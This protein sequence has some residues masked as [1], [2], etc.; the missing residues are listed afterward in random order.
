MDSSLTALCM[1]LLIGTVVSGDLKITDNIPSPYRL[2]AGSQFSLTCEYDGGN[3]QTEI[4]FEKDGHLVGPQF[5]KAIKTVGNKVVLTI[6]LNRPNGAEIGDGGEFGCKYGVMNS[7]KH[8]VDIFEVKPTEAVVP[9]KTEKDKTGKTVEL[10]CEPTFESIASAHDNKYTMEWFKDGK[11]LSE[12]ESLKGRYSEDNS[13]LTITKAKR[14]DMGKYQCVFVFADNNDR[15][16]QTVLLKGTPMIDSSF[17]PSKNLVQGDDWRITCKVTGF[18]YPEVYWSKEGEPLPDD[19]R[20]HLED[21]GPYVGAKLLIYSL[22]FED[23]GNYE[24]HS[25]STSAFN[26]TSATVKLRVKDRLATLW[27]F[28]G[29]VTEVIIMFFI[30]Q[31]DLPP[32]GPSLEL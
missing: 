20:I 15:I 31:I 5:N 3:D 11:Q 18:P 21:D 6:T 12:I 25:N 17:P 26:G 22:T 19:T 27:P 7:F 10:K 16:N 29:I 4:S 14:D 13:S 28:L 1:L 8:T 24:C 2:I 23:Q 9:V 30:L 32:S